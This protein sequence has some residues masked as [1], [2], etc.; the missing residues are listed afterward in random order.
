MNS[1]C[2]FAVR[3]RFIKSKLQLFGAQKQD[4]EN[5]ESIE[6]NFYQNRKSFFFT[7]LHK[8]ALCEL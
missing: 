7:Y 4:Y 3:N 2:S 5:K 1:Q 6:S 8:R